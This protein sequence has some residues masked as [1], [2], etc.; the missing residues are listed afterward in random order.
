MNPEFIAY[1]VVQW[2]FQSGWVTQAGDTRGVRCRL[3]GG[4]NPVPPPNR[5]ALDWSVV[6]TVGGLCPSSHKTIQW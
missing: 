3:M 1:K 6:F 5:Q 2:R 4:E